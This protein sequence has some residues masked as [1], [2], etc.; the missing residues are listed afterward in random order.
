M[1]ERK[2]AHWM[3]QLDERILEYIDRDGMATPRMMARDRAFTASPSH[4]WE[5][6][7]MLYYIR[8]VEPI[9][10]D[11]YD[12]TTD[13][14]LYLQGKIDADHRPKPTVERVLGG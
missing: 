12:L 11:M 3:K 10:S 14:M 1:N 9:Y 4:I 5:R 13:G 8:F 2:S 7:Q 6:C